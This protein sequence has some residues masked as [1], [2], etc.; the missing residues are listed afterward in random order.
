MQPIG[1]VDSNFLQLAA[2]LTRP[3]KERSYACMHISPGQRV[4][5]VGCGPGTDTIPLARLV[6]PQGQAAGV[7]READ[8]IAKAD[9]SARA[10]GLNGQITHR[11]GDIAELPFEADS[12]DASRSERLFQHL[13]Q[14][15]QALAEMA[16]VTKPGGW[17]V[18]MDTDWG[19]LSIDSPLV[20]T[21]RRLVRVHTLY[22]QQNSY[23]GRQLYGL[24]KRQ[25]LQ[26][27]GVE[28]I[29][30]FT[31]CYAIARQI[32][33]LDQVEQEAVARAILSEA[34]CRQWRLNLE[35]S[36]AEGTFFASLSMVLVAGRKG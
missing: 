26:E 14:P 13:S 33:N 19:S 16:R 8:M 34:A 32:A 5:D 4:L 6:G 11:L 9:A 20:D 25:G 3:A 15:E 24:L 23:S 29:P 36:A 31:T 18:V 17:V 28:M 35:K 22:N 21:E 2:E 30:L 10:A 27:I 7:D 1:T 12:F